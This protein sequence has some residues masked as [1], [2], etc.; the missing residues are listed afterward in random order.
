MIIQT[1][2]K[3]FTGS[4][5]SSLFDKERLEMKQWL[6]N[7]TGYFVAQVNT[8]RFEQ[9]FLTYAS[10]KKWSL[11]TADEK[12]ALRIKFSKMTVGSKQSANFATENGLEMRAELNSD[13]QPYGWFI[14][15][16]PEV[17]E[18]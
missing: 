4:V 7:P 5:K 12:S 15:K 17:T 6:I 11:L 13:G 3:S 14:L 9:D 16:A 18:E 1:I 2:T 10:G 8:A